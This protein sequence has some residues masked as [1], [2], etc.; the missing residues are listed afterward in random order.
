MI[1]PLLQVSA[2][3]VES[4]AVAACTNV[5]YPHNK[6]AACHEPR[7]FSYTV[8]GY[9]PEPADMAL[10]PGNLIARKVR[11]QLPTLS[12]LDG[13]GHIWPEVRGQGDNW[14]TDWGDTFYFYQKTSVRSILF[15][16]SALPQTINTGVLREHA[17]RFNSSVTCEEVA[18]EDFPDVCS[19]TRPLAGAFENAET[20]NRF[21][22]PGDYASTPWTI[23]R[24]RQDIVEELWVDNYIPFGS[25][26]TNRS[27]PGT[28]QVRNLT[29]HCTAGTTR[30]YF[31]LPNNHNGGQAGEV[32]QA[33]PSQAV[34]EADFNDV[35]V[36]SVKPPAE[37]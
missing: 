7:K 34:L 11:A 14:A 2:V 12:T 10:A 20:Q 25:L 31:E 6:A 4:N 3:R 18:R 15:Y 37:S 30:G 23:S 1:L 17:I 16:V 26:V 22:V 36:L 27:T 9:D 19:G 24:N 32:L 5:P 21:C 35:E 13:L 28:A 29:V 8:G 33:W